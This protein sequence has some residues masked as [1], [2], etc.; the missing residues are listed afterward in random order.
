MPEEANH[1]RPT[2]PEAVPSLNSNQTKPSQGT[3]LCPFKTVNSFRG[4]GQRLAVT[5]GKP[6]LRLGLLALMI[7]KI[8]PLAAHVKPSLT[9]SERAG[10]L[11]SSAIPPG[12]TPAG[13]GCP[14]A[15]P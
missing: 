1:Q 9:H 14:W 8:W 15:A 10:G 4:G 6:R 12:D 3:V 13:T 11:S 2:T 5:P 7:C